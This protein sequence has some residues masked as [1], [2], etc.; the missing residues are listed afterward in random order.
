MADSSCAHDVL[1]NQ[2]ADE[3]AAR[4]RRGERP[5]LADYVEKYPELADDIRDLFPALV[6]MERVKEDCQEMEPPVGVL[7]PLQQL[8]D[9]RILREIGH[10]GMGVVY[11]AEQISLGR[12]VAL[13][14][15]PPNLRR[16]SKQRRRFEREVRAAARLHHTNI[17]PVFGVGEY[18]GLPYYAMQFIQGLG[19]DEV[20]DELK[21]MQP[22]GHRSDGP[23]VPAGNELRAARK[24]VSAADVARSLIS[25]RFEPR[26]VLPS[27]PAQQDEDDGRAAVAE[28]P[29]AVPLSPQPKEDRIS[30]LSPHVAA[31]RLSDAFELSGS[32]GSVPG[33]REDS[34]G[35]N[36]KL[37]YWQSIARIGVQVASALEYAHQQGIL[38]RDIKPSNLLLDTRGT[39]W[40]TD[41][42]LAKVDDQ[43]NLTDTGDVLGT[44]RYMP[45]E[46]FDGRSDNRGDVYSLG[47]TLYEML[48][49]RP[50]FTERERS[51]LIK[52]VTT[53]APLRLE[54]LNRA[55]PRDLVT[56][57]HKAAEHDPDHRYSTAGELAADLQRF[58]DDA[59]IKVRRISAVEQL[60]RWG[61]RHKGVAAAL[62]VIVILLMTFAVGAGVTAQRLGH[63]AEQRKAALDQV[64]LARDEESLARNE[65]RWQRYR[66]NM[67]L[68]ASALELNNL[69]TMRRVL[70]ETPEEYRGFWEWHHFHSQVDN[71]RAVL[72]PI[73]PRG[74]LTTM[75][76]S[77]NGKRIAAWDSSVKLI[78]L[79][80]AANRPGAE[81]AALYGQEDN[82]VLL[83]YSPDSK[84]LAS[85]GDHGGLRLWDVETGKPR[86]VL[87]Q[88][89]VPV[90][91]QG[92]AYA[93]DG[94]RIVSCNTDGLRL[95]DP[96]TG[97]ETAF[98][99]KEAMQVQVALSPDGCR[100]AARN[101]NDIC[102]W[103][104]ATGRQET[105]L[106]PNVGLWSTMVFSPDG[107][108]IAYSAADTLLLWDGVTGEQVARLRGHN[109]WA[110][111]LVF[112]PDGAGCPCVM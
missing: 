98:L 26:P 109:A 24:D 12:H 63:L 95:W 53:G 90:N 14:I 105:V 28:D 64:S 62:G 1:L 74:K 3:F 22:G 83:A 103:D 67:G 96:A 97:K 89:S 44:V 68:A 30:S 46:A 20:I 70:D 36:R 9:Y 78:R 59:P 111:C 42:G 21:R 71:A 92:L 69:G 54:R 104:V 38:H 76:V 52:A 79:W 19:L 56:I 72:R 11:E 84:Q 93:L 45:P 107:R 48:V 51:K 43:E 31:G 102:L 10:G 82:V 57:V 61:R 49:L 16:E 27:A 80:D 100:L 50:A 73:E 5:S 77:P 33:S 60:A 29:A 106:G 6:G 86:A 58:L 17:V 2:L 75:T 110:S 15:L 13:K 40:V 91:W 39:V 18:D 101:G 34:S 55:I 23:P 32:S 37:T 87:C 112:S 81:T 66:A 94:R 7:P 47:L 25:G 41:F 108:R 8:G 99:G 4:Y 35:G 85:A 88:P 65:E